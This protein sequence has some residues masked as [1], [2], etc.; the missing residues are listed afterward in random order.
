M[1]EIVV[2]QRVE[3][4]L[5]K[6]VN[7]EEKPSIIFLEI[8]TS[9]SEE[10]LTLFA[11]KVPFNI[12]DVEETSVPYLNIYGNIVRDEDSLDNAISTAINEDD[13][14]YMYGVLKPIVS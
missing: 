6:I 1:K 14:D 2:L 7:H 13:F 12:E 9:V 8:D 5:L 4:E 3:E 11:N 10:I